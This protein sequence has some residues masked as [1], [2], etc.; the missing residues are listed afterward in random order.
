MTKEV[1]IEHLC[2][3]INAV[4]K[5]EDAISK[6]WRPKLIDAIDHATKEER[7]RIAQEYVHAIANETL[8][9]FLRSG[10]TM[11]ELISGVTNLTN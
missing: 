11:E 3:V 4:F 9:G 5:A 1:Y 10:H 7:D 8:A 6:E 2:D